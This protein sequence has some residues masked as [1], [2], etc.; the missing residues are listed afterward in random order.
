MILFFCADDHGQPLQEGFAVEEVAG[1]DA[2][3]GDLVGEGGADALAGG[4]DGVAAAGVL[5]QALE[6]DVVGHNEVGAVADEESGGIDAA[7]GEVVDLFDEHLGINHDAVADDGDGAGI[8]D[9]GGREAELELAEGIDDGMAGVIA[10]GE[11]DHVLGLL[12]EHVDYLAF[13]FVSPLPPD[14][15]NDRHDGLLVQ[16]PFIV[17]PK[18]RFVIPAQ[19]GIVSFICQ[20]IYI[21]IFQ[22]RWIL[23][24]ARMT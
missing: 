11:A 1:A 14:N 8:E 18:N 7:G 19:A 5:F 13:A 21:I 20:D 12:R 15:R 6:N 22:S 3:A 4:A 23:A 10:A 16:N 17:P 24:C 9:A 2:V